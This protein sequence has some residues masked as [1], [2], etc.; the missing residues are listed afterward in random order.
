MPWQCLPA[1]LVLAV[2]AVSIEGPPPSRIGL[3]AALA[4]V[5][6]GVIGT[7]L[8]FWAMTVVTRRVPANTAAL[9]VL[10]TPVVGIGL[11]ALILGE[12]LDPVLLSSAILIMV[13]VA[14]GLRS[15]S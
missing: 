14:V 12:R 5:Y 1:S 8:G 15:R 13:G 4:L 2:L 7:A 10:A 6:N 9:G 3:A 11:A